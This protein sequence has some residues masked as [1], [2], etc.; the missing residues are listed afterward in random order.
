MNDPRNSRTYQLGHR[1]GQGGALLL[2][3]FVVLLAVSMLINAARVAWWLTTDHP[4]I[5]VPVAML[6]VILVGRKL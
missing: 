4:L 3:A 2:G 5:A 6:G 1:I